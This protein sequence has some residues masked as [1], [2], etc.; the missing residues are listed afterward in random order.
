MKKRNATTRYFV[1]DDTQLGD[2]SIVVYRQRSSS[3]SIQFAIFNSG[4]IGSSKKT[5]EN[6]SFSGRTMQW[7]LSNQFREITEQELAL[8]IS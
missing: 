7:L 8:L 4:V 3:L 2:G 6:W 1:K 5:Y